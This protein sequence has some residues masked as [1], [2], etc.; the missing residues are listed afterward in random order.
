MIGQL[1]VMHSVKKQKRFS[2]RAQTLQNMYLAKSVLTGHPIRFFL[3][4]ESDFHSQGLRAV[5]FPPGASRVRQREPLGE[6]EP[7]C[8]KPV[9]VC[10]VF[11]DWVS[12]Q[13]RNGCPAY[14]GLCI[15]DDSLVDPG[16]LDIWWAS[17]YAT[18]DDVY[19]EKIFRY[20]GE[21]TNKKGKDI[22]LY[23]AASWSFKANCRQHGKVKLF[24][25]EKQ[26][27]GSYSESK[28]KYLQECLS[29]ANKK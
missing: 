27:K 29:Y 24:A 3:D 21:D 8:G 5:G 25:E 17:F 4:R 15:S 11:P 1:A 2:Q 18:G 7:P 26:K 9:T 19:L 6:G 13:N 16:K 28:I 10:P 20:A 14:S 12:S 23:G 22:L